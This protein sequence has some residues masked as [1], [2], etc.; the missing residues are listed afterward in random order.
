MCSVSKA[1]VFYIVASHT[2]TPTL[3]SINIFFFTSPDVW[4]CLADSDH[5]ILVDLGIEL[6]PRFWWV[7]CAWLGSRQPLTLV[8]AVS[9]GL[10]AVV[11]TVVIP[12]AGPVH[13]D[14]APAVALEL[15]AGAGVAAASFVAVV[16]TVVVWK[17][18]EGGVGGG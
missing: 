5:T 10:V 9:V 15:V 11:P 12:V 13:G 18:E 6:R 2:H 17:A 7:A 1:P 8:G 3:V 4:L 14:A 16:P